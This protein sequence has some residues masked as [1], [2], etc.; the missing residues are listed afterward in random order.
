VVMIVV[1][2]IYT[3]VLLRDG[4][5]ICWWPSVIHVWSSKNVEKIVT[6]LKF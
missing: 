6:P 2:T 4:N 3:F 5:L 1:N